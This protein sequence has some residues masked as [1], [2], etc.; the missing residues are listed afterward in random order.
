MPDWDAFAFNFLALIVLVFGLYF[1]R[2]R[3]KDLVA[4]LVGIN[5]GVLAVATALVS[6]EATVGV[7][8]GLFAVLSIIRLRSLELGQ[9]EV[10]YYFVALALG[11]VGAVPITPGWLP[12]IL[13]LALLLAM[14]VGDHPR[15]FA[16][17]R[18]QT[19]TLD[20]A[21]PGRE[22][23]IARLEELLG[24][25]VDG[26]AVRDLNFLNDSTRVEVRFREPQ[27]DVKEN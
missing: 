20:H 23:L 6:A 3:R 4:A 12:P 10:A 19:I 18:V 21:Y 27:F 14:Y 1:P 5:V 15:L 13:M 16:S 9:Q 22:M 8:L 7:G 17:Y 25:R 24:T 2:H 11:V 26:V